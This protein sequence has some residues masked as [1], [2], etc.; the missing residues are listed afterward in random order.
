[1]SSSYTLTPIRSDA[2]HQAALKLAEA[3]FDAPSEPDPDSPE[4]AHFE[5]LITLIEAYEAK[6]YPVSP[7][8]PIAAIRFRMEQAGLS[9]ADLKPYIGGLNRVYEVLSGKRGL[10]LTMI[11]KLHRGLG[12]PL[13]SLIGIDAD[14]APSAR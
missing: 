9:A 5:A 10:S 12:V 2:D 7:P 1:M 6:H 11:R 8:D 4:G 3:Y 13:S 14:D